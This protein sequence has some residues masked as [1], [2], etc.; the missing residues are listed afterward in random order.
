MDF[1]VK[2][3]P[4]K[5]LH[6]LSASSLQLL[7]NE[8]RLWKACRPS[9][10]ATKRWGTA[11]SGDGRSVNE[12]LRTARRRHLEVYGDVLGTM[13]LL[14]HY[15]ASPAGPYQEG[16]QRAAVQLSENAQAL[17]AALTVGAADEAQ[18]RH[19]V[20]QRLDR[21]DTT[22]TPQ[23][24]LGHPD[25]AQCGASGREW[26]PEPGAVLTGRRGCGAAGLSEAW[27]RRGAPVRL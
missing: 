7:R 23:H 1:P 13:D 20:E 27:P 12:E 9:I 18:Q 3:W 5:P 25:A 22:I 24:S 15:H 16:L 11:D 4:R 17:R 14:D 6:P 10:R 19:Q 26:P 21:L 2:Y 8:Y